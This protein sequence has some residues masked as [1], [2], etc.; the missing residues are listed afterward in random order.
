MIDIALVGN[1]NTGKTTFY[2]YI[3]KSNEHVGNWHGVTVDAKEKII[4]IN[5]TRCNVVDLPG[6]YSLSS[7][8]YEEQVAIDYLLQK[9]QSKIINICDGNNLERNLYL[10]LQLLEAGL[11]PSIYI[12]FYN[13][14]KKHYKINAGKLASILGVDV[15]LSDRSKK[16][17]LLKQVVAPKTQNSSLPYLQKIDVSNLQQ[18]IQPNCSATNIDSKF[19]AIK[20]LEQDDKIIEI[21]KLN[22][23]QKQKIKTCIDTAKD[24]MKEIAEFRYEYIDYIIKTCVTKVDDFVYCQYKYDKI[25]MHR[26]FALPI[27]VLILAAIFFTTFSSVGR[28]FSEGIKNFISNFIGV[29][30]NNIL[31]KINAPIWVV[32]MVSVCIVGGVGGL[33]SFLPQIALLFVF[34]QLLEDSG[35]LSRLAFSL[36]DLFCKVGLSGKSIFSLLMGLGCAT[37]AVMTCR[38]LE[39]KNAKI[40]AAMVVPYMSCSAKLPLY[41][42]V[43]STFFAGRYIWII[44]LL[45]LVGFIV[46]LTLS[47][48]FNKTILPNKELSFILEF[49]PYRMPNAKRMFLTIYTN[50]K[51]FVLKVSSVVFCVSICVWV[52]ENFSFN[53]EYIADNNGVSMLQSIGKVLSPIFAPIGL[54]NWGIV[55]CLIVG[56]V[57]KE[58]I[59]SSLCIFNNVPNVDSMVSGLGATFLVSTSV[60]QFDVITS[61]IFLLFCLLYSPC[62]STIS[63]LKQ[64]IGFKWTSIAIVMQFLVA[65]SVCLIVYNIWLLISRKNIVVSLVVLISYFVI[66]ISVIYLIKKVFVKRSCSVCGDCNKKCSKFRGQLGCK[67]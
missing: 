48:I 11:V 19:C 23:E 9:P 31:L 22:D 7:F 39:D 55:S 35:Y 27:F 3:T 12:N 36:E 38:N 2:N 24:N 6:I 17:N 57:A 18:I 1:P 26:V 15:Y 66:A 67:K 10:T 33:I 14:S 52:L 21:L 56:L 16:E 40:K 50:C 20:I 65:Y 60:V 5:N 37:S 45:Y 41:T 61:T 49:A 29:P 46:A 59:V 28:S 43:A 58:L 64:E 4:N 32:D 30:L 63:V 34:L 13:K 42:I 44:L 25:I 62:L 53:F 51:Q 47:A 54:N 8:S